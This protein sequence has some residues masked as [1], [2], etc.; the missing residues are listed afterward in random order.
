MASA[1]WIQQAAHKLAASLFGT[2]SLA[3]GP[4]PHQPGRETAAGRFQL[5]A[6]DLSA[7]LAIDLLEEVQYYGCGYRLCPVSRLLCLDHPAVV[8][9]HLAAL[10]EEGLLT[11]SERGLND[12]EAR[13]TLTARGRG[14][15]AEQ[16]TVVSVRNR[17][18]G[19]TSCV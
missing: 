19:M 12:G 3:L 9:A 7:E 11:C 16:S 8:R 6:G 14:M 2:R 17:D 1:A 4:H 10:V 15:M 13:V 18:T 5:P